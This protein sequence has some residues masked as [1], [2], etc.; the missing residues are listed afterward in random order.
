MEITRRASGDIVDV[1]VAGR[2]DGYWSDHLTSA[3]S[4]IVREGQ[5]HI[6]LDCAQVSFLS[7]AGIG[8]L[9][10]FHKELG[11]INGTFQ[12]INPSAPVSAV[13]RVTRLDAFLIPAPAARPTQ[14]AE[15]PGRRFARDEVG[16]DVFDLEAG[17]TLTCHTIGTAAP[18]TSGGFAA[19]QSASLEAMAPA[20]AVG[21]GAFGESFSD[22]QARFGELLSVA[23]ATA[24]QPADGSNVPDYLVSSGTLA[25]DVR[26]LYCLVCE[27]RFSHLVRFETLQPGATIGLSRLLAGCL[28]AVSAKSLGMVIVAEAAGLVGAA[29]RRSPAQPLGDA[30]FFAHP[31]VRTRLTFTAE[32]AFTRSVA[33]AAG[34]V[35]RTGVTDPGRS[36][37]GV[38]T[39]WGRAGDGLGTEPGRAEQFR[40]IGPDCAGHFHAAA[41]RFRPIRKGAIDL[42]ET[43][44]GLFEPDQLLGVLHLLH[45]DRGIGGAGESEFVR[46]ACW[47]SPLLNSQ[48][49]SLKSQSSLNFQGSIKS[50]VCSLNSQGQGSIQNEF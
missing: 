13:L 27:G 46:G 34:V 19:G 30:G 39:G 36:G 35:T 14:P 26:V 5:H 50:Q 9:M 47:V 15:R 16:F 10:K 28:D 8:V 32:R 24:Y 12:V 38:G 25:A 18:L 2:L 7:S 31:G 11:R 45:D 4:E 41:F 43:V 49:S 3:L 48:G 20:L 33:L 29:L 23:G 37:D 22:C 44:S 42:G 1:G 40:P 21:V 6:R 17:A